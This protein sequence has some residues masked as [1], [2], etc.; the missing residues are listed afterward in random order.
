MEHCPFNCDS[1]FKIFKSRKEML[2]LIQKGYLELQVDYIGSSIFTQFKQTNELIVEK[3][4]RHSFRL[5]TMSR[6]RKWSS[7]RPALVKHYRL[8]KC[9]NF[10]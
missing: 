1:D 10:D 4:F 7:K 3:E 8:E 5:S 2:D 9:Q 6:A